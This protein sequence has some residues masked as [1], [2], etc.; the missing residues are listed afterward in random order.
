MVTRSRFCLP[1]IR[2]PRVGGALLL[3]AGV[4]LAGCA[5]VET[6]TRRTQPP[7]PPPPAATAEQIEK[8]MQHLQQFFLT[9][10]CMARL[11]RA[12]P[13]LTPPAE[14]GAQPIYALEF[15]Q[16]AADGSTYR[17]HVTERDRL[18]YLY[19]SRGTAGWYTVRGP[20]PLWKCLS[21]TLPR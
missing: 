2:D 15:P 20:L 18:A 12:A 3:G 8:E 9:D 10:A 6:D 13:E 17:L 4:L 16:R 11:R 5:T 21:N 1:A 7:S 14:Q 19:T